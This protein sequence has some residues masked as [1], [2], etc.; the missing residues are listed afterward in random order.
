MTQHGEGERHDAGALHCG[1]EPFG[2]GLARQFGEI[3]FLGRQ[4]RQADGIE[5]GDLHR[6]QKRRA[7]G[8]IRGTIAQR[9][10]LARRVARRKG[11]AGEELDRHAAARLLGDELR[12]ALPRLA[13]RERRA[14]RRR[15]LPRRGL[16]LLLLG[17]RTCRHEQQRR[18]QQDARQELR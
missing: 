9:E 14:D 13:Q 1:S 3:L 18:E 12:P 6:P 5:L 16:V 7:N 15:Q 11:R 8:E 2:D 4:P 17:W 10:E